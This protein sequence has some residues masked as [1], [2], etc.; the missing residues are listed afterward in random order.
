MRDTVQR[1]GF[2][3]V[4]N[5]W[6]EILLRDRNHPSIVGWCAFNENFEDTGEL[7]QMI[8]NITK[9]IDPTRPALE[10]SGWAHTLPHPE[11]RDAHDYTGEPESLR[12]RWENFFTAP[13]EGPF[14][15]SITSLH[16]RGTAPRRRHLPR[17][18][19]RSSLRHLHGAHQRRIAGRECW[20]VRRPILHRQP[21]CDHGRDDLD[22]AP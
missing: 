17:Q 6:I 5:E 16:R 14:P 12:K 9:A 1:E 18:P 20:P 8:W 13:P 21:R 4:V 22:L 7:Q 2:S 3:A 19:R 15:P 10:S 11:V